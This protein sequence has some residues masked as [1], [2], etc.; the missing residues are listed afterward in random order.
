MTYN[1]FGRTLNL[2][3][4][5]PTIYRLGHPRHLS[6]KIHRSL[7]DCLSNAGHCDLL[8]CKF[9]DLRIIL[10]NIFDTRPA[11]LQSQT[12]YKQVAT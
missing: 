6:W 8:G 7:S 5:N 4:S 10:N 9:C 3:Q 12:Q 11:K 2:A 1:V